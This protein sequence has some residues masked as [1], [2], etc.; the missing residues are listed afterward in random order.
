MCRPR[1]LERQGALAA[2]TDAVNPQP[3]A[4]CCRQIASECRNFRFVC[5]RV[6][7]IS[8]F[9]GLHS[10][11]HDDEVQ[12]YAFDILMSD[13]EDIRKLPLHLRKAS[14]A[15]LF[16]RRVDGIFL[17]DFEQGEIGPRFRYVAGTNRAI[18]RSE[19]A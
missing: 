15:R 6:D 8:D 1:H 10:R 9:N 14:L 5:Q 4:D 18:V 3:N 16:A 11:N 7:G 17:S 12:F 19:S 2:P 13:G